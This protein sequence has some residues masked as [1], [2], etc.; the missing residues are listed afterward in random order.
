MTEPAKKSFVTTNSITSAAYL[1]KTKPNIFLSHGLVATA[2]E[3]RDG[4]CG[5]LLVGCEPLDQAVI[6]CL[7]GVLA[8]TQVNLYIK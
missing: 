5:H 4:D 3:C 2:V 8:L 6:P 1:C 7:T